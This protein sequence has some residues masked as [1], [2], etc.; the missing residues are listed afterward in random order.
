MK[1]LAFAL[2]AFI[3][4]FPLCAEKATLN[5]G[6]AFGFSLADYFFPN[7][8]EAAWYSGQSSFPDMAGAFR[9]MGVK[10]VVIKTGPQGC[11]VSGEEG[12]FSLP[13]LPVSVV[14]MTGAGDS[15]VA[16]FISGILK[17]ASLKECAQMAL[18]SA[19]KTITHIGT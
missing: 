13:A 8:K 4:I 15:F 19:S 5:T 2:L 16:G 11:Y 1:K 6:D 17:N 7:E 12:E 9:D 18:L 14:D 3:F 10:N